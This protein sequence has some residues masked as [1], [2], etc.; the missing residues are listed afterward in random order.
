DV[1][2]AVRLRPS[3]FQTFEASIYHA[4]NQL[5][6]TLTALNDPGEG[7]PGILMATDDLYDWVNWAAQGQYHW[8]LGSRTLVSTHVR[9][10]WHDSEY[11]YGTG[12]AA[13]P[14]SEEAL[15]EAAAELLEG[16]RDHLISDESNRIVETSIG[17]DVHH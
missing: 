1:H 7:G 10:S 11:T 13:A 3:T 15:D 17:V 9:G 5:A 12:L 8:V 6:S 16:A 2:A 4:R 14:E